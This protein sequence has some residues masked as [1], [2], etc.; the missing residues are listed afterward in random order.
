MNTH[1]AGGTARQLGLVTPP[2]QNVDADVVIAPPVQVAVQDSL[3][4]TVT[5]A[6]D[7]V[8]LALGAPSTGA[9]LAG[10]TTVVTVD[11]IATFADLRVDRPGTYTLVA[12]ARR[13]AAAT[14]ASFAVRL[15]FAALSAG[16]SHT[17]ALTRRGLA[18]CWGSN[19]DGR[20]GDGTMLSRPEPGLVAG[21]SDIAAVS[22]GARHACAVTTGGS[23]YCWGANGAGQLGDGTTTSRAIPVPVSG[24]LAF[25][26]LDGGG[27]HSCGVITSGASYCWGD[28]TYGQLGDGTGTGRTNPAAVADHLEFVSVS[29]G[30]GHACGLTP[31]GTAYCWGRNDSGQLGDGNTTASALPVPVQQESR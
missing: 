9:G 26:V 3:G 15:T 8:T 14:S 16:G 28:N 31:R 29:A 18:Y 25:A 17:C 22:A 7:T 10:T 20:L 2:P 4:K 1:G 6:R 27:G 12:T 5:S 21:V 23:A 24:G 30:L 19:G 11:G 13:L